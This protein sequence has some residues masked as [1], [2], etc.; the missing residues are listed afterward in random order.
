M[1][2]LLV[3]CRRAKP[4]LRLYVSLYFTRKMPEQR[5]QWI[6]SDGA[7]ATNRRVGHR[8]GQIGNHAAFARQRR[9]IAA[10][11]PASD[12]ISGD[13]RKLRRANPARHALAAGFAAVEPL[14]SQRLLDKV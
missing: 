9:N 10:L 13:F 3:F 12:Q 11:Q 4:A 5:R 8:E 14:A 7:Q 1:P 6:R 2:A